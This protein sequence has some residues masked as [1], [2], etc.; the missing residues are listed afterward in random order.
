MAAD[1]VQ[2]NRTRALGDAL[3]QLAEHLRQARVLSSFLNATGQHCFN[4]TDY[5]SMEQLFGLNAGTGAN[6][7]TLIGNL[8]TV[9]NSSTTVDGTTRQ[10]QLLEFV[11]RVAGQ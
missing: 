2:V 4:G 7:L 5:T 9:L 3:V 11:S 1:Y 8:D 10:A 6:C